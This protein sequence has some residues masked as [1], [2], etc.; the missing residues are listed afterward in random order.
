MLIA[1]IGTR[2]QLIK[3]AP[4]LRELERRGHGYRLLLTGQHKETMG[5]LLEEFEVATPAEYLYSGAEISGIGAMA[6]WLPKMLFRLTERLRRSIP[7]QERS[8]SAVLVHGDTFSTLLGA[9]A[10]RLSGMKVIHIE[11]GLRS[12]K[13]FD[14]FPEELTRMATFR[15]SHLAF[16]PGKWAADNMRGLPPEVI[17]THCNTLIDAVRF[18]AGEAKDVTQRPT[19]P[20]CVA[21]IHRFENIFNKERLFKIVQL[22]EE[23]A[24]GQL[25]IFV[26]HP[27]TRRRLEELGLRPR[28]E[29]NPNVQLVPRMTYLPFIQLLSGARFAVSDGGSNQ[30]ELSYLGIPTLLMREATE[31]QE[32]LDGTAW[33]CHL[34]KE[35]VDA[36]LSQLPEERTPAALDANSPSAHIVD[37]LARRFSQ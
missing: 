7:K 23:I 15:L 14:P 37:E 9:V 36:F 32:G 30:E 20:Y 19:H 31:R 16:C 25:V 33:L 35:Q 12:F 4:V 17:N 11:A 10:G 29:A 5:A 24:Q 34:A 1:I 13:P 28:L 2:A 27:A 6:L 21:S 26:L 18:A 8:A 22:L 3:M